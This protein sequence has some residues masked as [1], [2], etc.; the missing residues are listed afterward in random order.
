MQFFVLLLS[1][2]PLKEVRFKNVLTVLVS[3]GEGKEGDN[4]QSNNE[5]VF[6]FVVSSDVNVVPWGR[7]DHV[8]RML[9]KKLHIYRKVCC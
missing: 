3:H 8:M 2:F 7:S 5:Y 6:H 1:V 4:D 9:S